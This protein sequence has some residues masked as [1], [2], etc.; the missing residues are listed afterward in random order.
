MNKEKQKERKTKIDLEHQRFYLV[1]WGQKIFSAIH[2]GDP[3]KLQEIILEA[4]VKVGIDV[5]VKDV[6]GK[7]TL[8]H[9]IEREKKNIVNILLKQGG[10]KL[11]FMKDGKKRTALH[12]AVK[13]PWDENLNMLLEQ[14]G[15]ELLFMKDTYGQT[16]LHFAAAWGTNEVANA[17][18]EKG[19]KELLFME[20]NNKYTALHLAVS[21][22]YNGIEVVKILLKQDGETPFFM[23]D[24]WGRTP[25]MIATKYDFNEVAKMLLKHMLLEVAIGLA[26]LNMPVLQVLEIA[27]Y[28]FEVD[29]E[30]LPKTIQW[31]VAKMV[32]DSSN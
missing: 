4:G 12:Y 18:L 23:K 32:K 29:L 15:K 8:M 26:K 31:E 1:D 17:L 10:K 27:S 3:V 20:D 11:L 28:L 9:A 22:V 14:G 7:T 16:A 6:Y 25:L 13:L 2:Y 5:M 30:L 19:G 21:H 24:E